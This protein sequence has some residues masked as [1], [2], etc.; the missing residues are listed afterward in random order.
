MSTSYNDGSGN[1]GGGPVSSIGQIIPRPGLT[2]A[3]ELQLRAHEAAERDQNNN[4]QAPTQGSIAHTIN[5]YLDSHGFTSAPQNTGTIANAFQTGA[6]PSGASWN[7]AN[8]R[9]ATAQGQ[10]LAGSLGLQDT[11]QRVGAGAAGEQ[12]TMSQ[13]QGAAI[14]GGVGKIGSAISGYF[15]DKAKAAQQAAESIGKIKSSIPGPEDFQ[16]K[17]VTSLQPLQQGVV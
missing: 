17:S 5:R 4:P 1:Y 6:P 3:Q 7:T 11:G 14:A 15:S 9:P 8:V 13:G 16:P 2:D 12:K 10:G